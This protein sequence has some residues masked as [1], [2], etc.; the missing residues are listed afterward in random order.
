M[1]YRPAKQ[2]GRGAVDAEHK[3]DWREGEGVLQGD[4]KARS[5]GGRYKEGAK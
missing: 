1:P 3:T 5:R 4:M 2:K